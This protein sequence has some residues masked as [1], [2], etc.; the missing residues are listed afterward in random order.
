MAGSAMTANLGNYTT[1][2]DSATNIGNKIM[3]SFA[4][5]IGNIVYDK[6]ATANA[7]DKQVFWGLDLFSYFFGSFV[8]T[9]LSLA[10]SSRLSACGWA[11]TACCRWAL[12]LCSA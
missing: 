4:A 7:H 12:L 6:S 9:A 11:V 2:S 5:A 10:C 1:V 8:A 3:D